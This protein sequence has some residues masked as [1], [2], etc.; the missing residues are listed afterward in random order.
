[1]SRLGDRTASFIVR[2]WRESRDKADAEVEWRGSIE[3]VD[4]GERLYFKELAAMQTF[5]ERHLQRLG[6]TQTIGAAGSVTEASQA[7]SAPR[8]AKRIR[9]VRQV[10]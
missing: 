1:M 2:A 7:P 6:I 9:R 5:V 4:S 8:Q 3:C 10:G